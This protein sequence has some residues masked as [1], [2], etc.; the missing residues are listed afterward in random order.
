MR[1]ARTI[2]LVG[3]G[4]L[5]LGIGP[6]VLLLAAAGLAVRPV[7]AWLRP[8]RLVVACWAAAAVALAGLVV[9][10][11]DGWLPI[12]PGPGALVT[13]AYVGRPAATGA[14]AGP[15]GESPTVTTRWYGAGDCTDLVFDGAGRLVALCGGERPVLRRVDPGSLRSRARVGLPGAGCAGRLAGTAD[16]VV[17]ASGRRIHAVE[18]RDLAVTA[19]VDLSGQLTG[20]DCVVGLGVDGA[21][22][23]WFVSGEGRVG[24]VHGDRVRTVDLDDVVE[25]PLTVGDGGAYVAGSSGLYRVGLRNGRPVVAWSATYDGGER[26]SAPVLLDDGVVA[27]ADNRAPR[28]QVVLHRADTGE[29]RCRA[30]V[31]DDDEGAADGGLVAAGDGVVVTNAD[32]YS[33]AHSTLLGRT[34]GRGLARVGADCTVD[35][36][37]EM[38]APSGAPAVSI[39]DGLLYAWTKRHSW[40]GVD[41]WYL[42][43]IEL[44]S[45]RLVWARRTGLTPFADNR[46]GAVVLGPDR[47]A[48]APVLGGLVRVAD[49]D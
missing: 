38:N 20:D 32:G 22:R 31:F 43:A 36:T 18:T 44:S 10:V 23:V 35:W 4:L 6:V 41:A 29:V 7:R 19:S 21:G 14:E 40:L 49:R 48:Y 1:F 9:V 33:G 8:T 17:V 5:W 26:G 37:L 2:A 13:P 11:P 3:V 28:L 30:E 42:S 25:R 46:R 34:T 47:A 27:V 12:P 15:V 45:G 24:V 39:A 16:G